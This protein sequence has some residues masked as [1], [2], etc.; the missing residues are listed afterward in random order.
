MLD[1][2]FLKKSISYGSVRLTFPLVWVQDYGGEKNSDDIIY[3]RYSSHT[4]PPQ[5]PTG[6]IE[7]SDSIPDSTVLGIFT[8]KLNAKPACSRWDRSR[9]D[10]SNCLSSDYG[11]P[12]VNRTVPL[13]SRYYIFCPTSF[14]AP[15]KMTSLEIVRLYFDKGNVF[16]THWISF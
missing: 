3:T 4:P 12:I 5:C 15:Y 10:L 1:Q 7:S 2:L 14:F 6:K 13:A 9:T 16:N 11:D 8:G